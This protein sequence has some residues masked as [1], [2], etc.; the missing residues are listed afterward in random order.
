M[1]VKDQAARNLFVLIAD[2]HPLFRLG[3][4]IAL[5]EPG[6]TVVGETG[7]GDSAHKMAQQLHPDV[8][9]LD[10]RMPGMDGLEALKR[11]KATCP[12]TAVIIVT[13]YENSEFL[14]EA[15]LNGAAAYLLKGSTG[16]D[17]V[18]LVR[19]VAEGDRVL[20][21]GRFSEM[22]HEFAQ[23]SERLSPQVLGPSSH[24][25]MKEREVLGFMKENLSNMEMGQRMGVK[26]STIKSHIHSI[27][28]KTG[29]TDRTQAVLW[30]T[31]HGLFRRGS[32]EDKRKG[33]VRA[34]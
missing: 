32:T 17:M 16:Q 11:I 29:V 8:A 7:D 9:I 5:Q 31:L 19:R 30:A 10:V 1:Q 21:H 23:V 28:Q 26:R 18:S 24:L 6:I 20:D 4:K 27:F 14:W 3:L 13:S 25:T 12:S 33:P 2:D 15:F 22:L 34:Q